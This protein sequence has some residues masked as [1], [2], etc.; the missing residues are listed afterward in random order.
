MESILAN[1][2][3]RIL[4]GILPVLL[5]LLALVFLDSY[6]LVRM[7]SLLP[8]MAGGAAAAGLSLLL[9]SWLIGYF[10]GDYSFYSRYAAP[11][12]EE[13]LKAAVLF[14]FFRTHRI[15]FLVD[16]AILGF[17]AGAGFSVAENLHFLNAASGANF[18]IWAVRGLGTAMMHGGTTAMFAS[19]TKSLIDQRMKKRVWLAAVPGLALACAVHS[20]F[21]HFLLPPIVSTAAM[22]ILLPPVVLNVFIAS[23]RN[24]RR[25]LQIGFDTDVELLGLVNAG[26]F[27]SSKIGRYLLSLKGKFSGEAMADLFCLIRLH[28][29]LSINAKGMLLMREAGLPAV[30]EPSL[31]EK[32]AELD[33]LQKSVG[34]TGLRA[35]SPILHRSRRDLWELHMLG[36]R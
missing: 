22:M 25:W 14:Y 11:L 19:L 36:G 6:K 17:A 5:F 2:G 13:S 31:Q 30:P 34:P 32:F 4:I 26:R 28:L 27:S 24:T 33:Y 35:V 16:A 1:I 10:Q 3:P 20:V 23:E 29:E 21:N 18:L 9:N 7:K 15:G 8:A 12:I